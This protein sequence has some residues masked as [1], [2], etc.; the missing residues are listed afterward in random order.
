M[1]NPA[2][3]QE[4]HELKISDR[5]N[6]VG[7]RIGTQLNSQR[8]AIDAATKLAQEAVAHNKGFVSSDEFDQVL[9][10][11]ERQIKRNITTIEMKLEHRAT[12]D[13]RLDTRIT[14]TDLTNIKFVDTFYKSLLFCSIF[15][16]KSDFTGQSLSKVYYLGV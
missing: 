9:N 12:I 1:L 8:V 2:K 14:G 10:T 6:A 7:A 15:L 5:I 11:I 3:D 4:Q 13:S 16:L